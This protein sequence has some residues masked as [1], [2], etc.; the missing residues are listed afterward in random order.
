[1][2]L[3]VGD[4]VV[5]VGGNAAHLMTVRAVDSHM[6][7][8]AFMGPSGTVQYAPYM[9]QEVELYEPRP[10]SAADDAA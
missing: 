9:P 3:K 7:L 1:M 8:C 4:T 10:A 6:V 5:L 2:E